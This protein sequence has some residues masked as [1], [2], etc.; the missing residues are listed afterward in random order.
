VADN[1]STFGLWG[2]ECGGSGDCSFTMTGPTAVS[3]SFV[4]APKARIVDTGY[5]SL[6]SAY[7]F[8]AASG[9]VIMTIDSEMPDKGLD[10]NESLAHGKTVTIRGGYYADYTRG[11]SGL[12]TYLKGPLYIS[13]GTLTVD[14]LKIH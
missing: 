12:P 13:S 4:L 7:K 8:A 14:G 3:A 5:P 9:D 10:I 2:G 11:R 6:A 1:I